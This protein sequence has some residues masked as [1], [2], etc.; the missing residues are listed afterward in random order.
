MHF[1]LGWDLCQHVFSSTTTIS[2][3]CLALKL[4][5]SRQTITE[6]LFLCCK[7]GMN[8]VLVTRSIRRSGQHARDH[9]NTESEGLSRR[10][11]TAQSGDEFV[12]LRT[13]LLQ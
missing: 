9:T 12:T 2:L 6:H 5:T 3:E 13:A 4:H 10:I 7:V 11:E 1:I 8:K